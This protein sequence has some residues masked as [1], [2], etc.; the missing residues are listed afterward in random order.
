M[1]IKR[2]VAGFLLILLTY[3]ILLNAISDSV[4]KFITY[5]TGIGFLPT[6]DQFRLQHVVY[7]ILNMREWKLIII[8]QTFLE[9]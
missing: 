7:K 5:K 8:I 2:Q 6:S 9:D 4:Y 1:Q 3:R